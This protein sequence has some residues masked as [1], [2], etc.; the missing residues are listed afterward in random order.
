MPNE[1][2]FQG[3][4]VISWVKSKITSPRKTV[5]TIENLCFEFY[6][7]YLSRYTE[8]SI[9]AAFFLPAPC[10]VALLIVGVTF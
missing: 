9:S 2:I 8:L 10:A 4:G 6:L 3:S 5:V 1:D 7:V